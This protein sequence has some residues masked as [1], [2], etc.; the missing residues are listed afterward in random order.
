MWNLEGLAGVAAL[1]GNYR[2]AA[3]LFGGAEVVR[4]AADAA[5]VSNEPE[6]LQ[7]LIG[8]ARDAA[9]EAVFTAEWAE[10]QRMSVEQVLDYALQEEACR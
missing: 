10:G 7:G 1:Q 8:R 9:G 2:R 5:M 6:L 4:A 3:R